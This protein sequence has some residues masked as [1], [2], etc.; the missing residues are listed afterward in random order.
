MGIKTF[1]E[2]SPLLIGIISL[3]GLAAGTTFSFYINELPFIKQ[4]YD[5]KAEFKDAAGLGSENQVRVAGIKVGTVEDV[6]LAGDRVLVT[7]SIENTTDIPKDAFAEIKLATILGTKFVDIEAKGG[8]PFLEEGDTIS[9][10]NTAIPYEI[11]QASNQGT[12]VLE[13]LD[14]EALNAMLEQVTKLI[15]VAEDEI[16]FALVSFDD[17]GR[18]LTDHQDELRQLLA[19]ADDLTG[20]LSDEGDELV[21]LIDASNSVLGTLAD[22]REEVQSLLAATRQMSGELTD[23]LRDNRENVDSILTDLHGALV[24]LERNVKH[25]DMA[26]EFAGPST[27]YFGSVFT[28]GRWGDIFPCALIFSSE[29]QG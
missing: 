12:A 18:G 21:R 26:F 11:Y 22:R 5:I 16:R 3:L 8:G 13:D 29:C 15:R 14:G 4:A 27:R 7:M 24:V 25:L 10:E 9:M 6:Q 23:I 17:L 20:L 1:R 19:G 28:Q 2:R